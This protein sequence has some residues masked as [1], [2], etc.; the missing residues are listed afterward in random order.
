MQLFPTGSSQLTTLLQSWV[1]CDFY[2]QV[3]DVQLENVCIYGSLHAVL[4][5]LFVLSSSGDVYLRS[6]SVSTRFHYRLLQVTALLLVQLLH[7]DVAMFVPNKY[8]SEAHG[9]RTKAF[10]YPNSNN[11][12]VSFNPCLYTMPTKNTRESV[13]LIHVYYLR[14]V[15]LVQRVHNI[16]LR[17]IQFC[18]VFPLLKG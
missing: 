8:Y 14:F 17:Y 4:Y 15:S 7:T 11:T 18:L 5:K 13:S 12:A 2:T 16:E 10:E 3:Y 1:I 9:L 6:D